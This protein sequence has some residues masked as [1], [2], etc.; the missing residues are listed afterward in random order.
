MIEIKYLELK[1]L[2]RYECG[3]NEE[4]IPY[5]IN[6]AKNKKG[7][8]F[9]FDFFG[10]LVY[11]GKSDSSIRRRLWQHLAQSNLRRYDLNEDDDS[12][13]NTNYSSKIPYGIIRYFSFFECDNY[14]ENDMLEKLYIFMYK[15][16]INLNTPR[17]VH[18]KYLVLIAKS[19]IKDK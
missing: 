2:D 6:E 14:L 11:I 10:N 8:Y 13:V 4:G 12:Y 19:L 16:F 3:V 18:D 15:P 7:I 1:E 17:L 5:G 9:L